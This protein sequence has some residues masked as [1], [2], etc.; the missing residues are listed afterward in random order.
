MSARAASENA[1]EAASAEPMTNPYAVSFF[2]VKV[3]YSDAFAHPRFRRCTH[4][5]IK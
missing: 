1:K 3:S 2:M 5:S 4:F